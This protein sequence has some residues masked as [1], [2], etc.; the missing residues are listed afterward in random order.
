MSL[1]PHLSV[2][3]ILDIGTEV[4]LPEEINTNAIKADTLQL[5]T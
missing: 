3:A 4:L 1:N 2:S 5:W